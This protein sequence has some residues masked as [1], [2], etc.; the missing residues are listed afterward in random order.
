MYALSFLTLHSILLVILKLWLCVEIQ[1]V[2]RLQNKLYHAY[3]IRNT[4]VYFISHSMVMTYLC[5]SLECFSYFRSQIT[6]LK[7]NDRD[8]SHL[9]GSQF[10]L[11]SYKTTNI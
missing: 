9:F 1:V 8:I 6:L 2:F 11:T 4:V 10:I 7:N 3:F 5:L